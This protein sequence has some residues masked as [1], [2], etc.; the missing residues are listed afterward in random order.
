[1]DYNELAIPDYHERLSGNSLPS[2]RRSRQ[3][4]YIAS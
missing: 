1:M 2:C 3:T 4:S